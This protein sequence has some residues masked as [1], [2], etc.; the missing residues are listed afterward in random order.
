MNKIVSPSVSQELN[1]QNINGSF[2]VMIEI[3]NP[4]IYWGEVVNRDN[5]E[6]EY[7]QENCYLRLIST[8]TKVIYNNHTWIPCNMEF[9]PPEVDGAKIGTASLT[10]SSIDAR[11]KLIL[12]SLKIPST[13]KA[14]ALFAK[15]KKDNSKGFI[16][17][18]I[19]L[20][21]KEFTME[22]ASSNTS[23]ATFNLVFNKALQQS[24]PYDVATP[25][26]TPAAKA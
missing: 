19:K 6:T 23:T 16:Y 21:G 3:Y 17:K 7:E 15:V 18:F 9:T 12:R 25:D 14:V 8:D 5:N 22:T 26:R 2:P 20:N 1:A 13:V 24:I 10:M 11:V 4:D